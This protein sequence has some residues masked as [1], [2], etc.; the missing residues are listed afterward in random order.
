MMRLIDKSSSR[1]DYIDA[2]R[3]WAILAVIFAHAATMAPIQGSL[4]RFADNGFMGVHLFFVISAFTIFHMLSKH[5]EQESKPIRNFFIRRLFRIAP[6]YWFG[7]IFYIVVWGLLPR[8]QW[9]H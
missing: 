7:I 4:R 8:S 2:L 5:A 9:W 6:V 3:G 1:F